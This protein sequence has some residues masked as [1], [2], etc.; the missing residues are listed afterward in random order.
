MTT[1]G[2][3]W[4]AVGAIALV[5]LGVKYHAQMLTAAEKVLKH[6]EAVTFGLLALLAA[7][8]AVIVLLDLA[9][10]DNNP[11]RWSVVIAV[12]ILAAAT[13]LCWLARRTVW[14]VAKDKGFDHVVP[15][16]VAD[17]PPTKI[18]Y[19]PGRR[20]TDEEYGALAP[21]EEGNVE[22]KRL[23]YLQTLYTGA[24]G[25]WST[26]K[27]QALLWTYIALFGLIALFI[28]DHLG[29]TLSKSALENPDGAADFGNL[30]F[31]PEYLLLLGGPF[32]AA[33]LSRGL[34]ASK[35][36]QGAIVKPDAPEDR[37]AFSGLRDLITNDAGNADVIDFQYLAFNL[38]A[39]FVVLFQLV[40][41]LQDGFPQIPDFLLGLTSAS[42]LAY[43]TKKTVERSKPTI[44]SV[45][46]AR[47]FPGETI[48]ISGRYLIAPPNG[49]P[50]VNIDGHNATV[51]AV[52]VAPAGD[53]S[54]VTVTIPADMPAGAQKGVSVLPQGATMA[55]T[56]T[57]EV[58]GTAVDQVAPSPVPLGEKVGLTI[59][60]KGFGSG[61]PTVTLGDAELAV[62][63]SDDTTIHAA[64]TET[65][66]SS[67]LRADAKLT[68]VVQPSGTPDTRKAVFEVP[69]DQVRPTI[70]AAD[71]KDTLILKTGEQ[72]VVTGTGFGAQQ[73]TGTIKLG[74]ASLVVI[75]WSDTEISAVLPEMA[76][77][78]G[79]T[80]PAHLGI[81]VTSNLGVASAS[82]TITVEALRITAVD[83]LPITLT[84]DSRVTVT[85]TGFGA[86]RGPKG[87]ITLDGAALDPVS[88]SDT[89][90]VASVGTQAASATGADKRQLRVTNATGYATVMS[91]AVQSPAPAS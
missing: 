90:I 59:T 21:G 49:K 10:Q 45:D 20:L 27:T 41:D 13:L 43:V 29:L 85:G 82:R 6:L 39:I 64:I 60:G 30:A 22:Q 31:R 24:D 87:G 67:A 34:V 23:R 55:A 91:V 57:V 62:V 52:F 32:A 74:N 65:P 70:T 25:R 38:L 5:V 72:V 37:A 2:V 53:D 47:A 16:P 8:S 76:V 88:W 36:D 50:T 4:A 58:L 40:P 84:P 81:V 79:T 83:R 69:V 61:T 54:S 33:V 71:P 75:G 44:V 19:A 12:V 48:K 1:G 17:P 28:G 26:S 51:T 86:L 78:A 77:D 11:K 80:A 63:Q 56:S 66:P 9:E 7:V 3:I 35:L 42:A 46:P 89:L 18:H 14:V 15:S 73:G 68:L